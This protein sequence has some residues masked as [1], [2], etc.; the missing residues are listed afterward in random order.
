MRALLTLA[1]LIPAPLLAQDAA[2][3]RQFALPPGCTAYLTIQAASCTLSHHFTC[4]GDAPGT[5]RRVDLDEGGVSYFGL[6]DGETQWIESNH[7]LAGRSE[8]LEDNPVDRASFTSL[9]DTGIDTYDF[10]T[11]SEPPGVTRF[12][13]QD[14]LTGNTVTIDG[15]TLDETDYAITAFAADGMEMWRSSGREYISRD[16]RMF[17][18]G[19]ST[20]MSS[21]ETWESDDTPVEFVFPDE[22]GFLT[23]SPKHGC[24]A[25]MSSYD[26]AQ[27]VRLLPLSKAV[28]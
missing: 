19:T 7:V 18:S 28:L 10:Q 17:V 22:P 6:I 20:I 16:F 4:D 13:G 3:P 24:G 21:G 27:S 26:P 5:Q 23:G 11:L 15:V 9:I 8:R 14:R 2:T 12:V 25:V 1:L